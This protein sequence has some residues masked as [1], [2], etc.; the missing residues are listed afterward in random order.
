MVL[1][2]STP[3]IAVSDAI[4]VATHVDAVVVVARSD[5]TTRDAAQRCRQ[6]LGRVKDVN[7]VGVVANAVREDTELGRTYYVAASA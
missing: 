1:I 7:V 5:Y 6:A 2:D 3:I 4:P